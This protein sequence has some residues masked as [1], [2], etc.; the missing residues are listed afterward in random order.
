MGSETNGND[1]ACR[2]CF[3]LSHDLIFVIHHRFFLDEQN[4][5]YLPVGF[6]IAG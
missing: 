3:Q 6:S 5:S 2:S 4:L 1:L